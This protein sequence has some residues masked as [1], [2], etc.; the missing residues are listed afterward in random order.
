MDINNRKLT[1]TW[2]LNNTLL[3]NNLVKEKN[4]EIKDFF[5]FNE[6][7]DTTCPKLWNTMKV[8]LKGTLTALSASKNKLEKY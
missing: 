4:K 6:N 1:Y 2:K 5:K 8:V 7:K 3:N